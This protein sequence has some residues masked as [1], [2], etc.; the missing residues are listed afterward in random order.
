VGRNDFSVSGRRVVVVGAARSGIA[1]A[2]LLVRRGAR[3]TLTETRSTFEQAGRLRERGVELE[4]GGHRAATLEAADLIASPES[5]W[6][7]GVRRRTGPGVEMIGELEL[8][9]RWVKGATGGDGDK[10]KVH[11]QR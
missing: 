4:V 3:V 6:S 7:N 2:E 5:R 1:A 8:A 10:G 11:D 9:W